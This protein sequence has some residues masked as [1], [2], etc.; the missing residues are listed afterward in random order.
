MIHIDQLGYAPTATKFF[1]ASGHTGSFAVV[2]T[3]SHTT[4]Y[5]GMT[6]HL[7]RDEASGDTVCRGDFSSLTCSGTYQIRLQSGEVS[8]PFEIS[9]TVHN[10][11]SDALLKA[12][13]Y[14]RCGC[15][16]TPQYAGVWAHRACHLAHGTVYDEP[17]TKLPSDG[18]WHD[19]GDYGKYTVAAAKAI[20]DLLLAY[21]Q[22]PAAFLHAINIPESGNETP[23]I[24]SEVR[25][26][27]EWLHK[28]QRADGSVFHKLTTRNF[29]PLDTMPEDDLGELVFAPISYTASAT[30]CAVMAMAARHYHEIDKTFA[31]E[32][33]RRARL[34]YAWL[35]QHQDHP[36]FVNPPGITTGEYGDPHTLD[37][38]YWASAELYRTT[39]ESVYHE[40]FARLAQKSEVDPCALGWADVGGYGTLAYLLA[41]KQDADTPLYDRLLRAFEARAQILAQCCEKDGYGV[42]LLPEQY[43]WGSMMALLNHAM[44]LILTDQVTG[45][46]TYGPLAVDHL[47]YL[48]GRNPLGQSYV[49][50]FGDR[51]LQHPHHRPSV[52]DGVAAPVPGLV[53]GGPNRHLQDAAAK[54]ALAGQPPAR[55]FIDHEDSY[56]TNEITIYWNSPAVFVAAYAVV[57]AR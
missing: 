28:M 20:A 7:T 50:G 57:T 41:G 31:R 24:L 13:Y 8:A 18:G 32:C 3:V 36:G 44:H 26:E 21:E 33:L 23:D 27:L 1:V 45:H 56:S 6:G 43:V 42:S 30:F 48:L 51:P 47:H 40:A 4:V 53:S 29:P 11:L 54:A 25:Y 35:E 55:C 14:Q 5:T 37:E 12:F 19:A 15:E 16:L 39:H 49:T 17:D 34:S 38:A 10:A 52:G 2:D 46:V 22:F 9:P